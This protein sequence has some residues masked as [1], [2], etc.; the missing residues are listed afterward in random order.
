[1][2]SST[3]GPQTTYV[4]DAASSG[5]LVVDFSRN[6]KSFALS[7]W[8]QYVP[9]KKTEGRYLLMTVEQA[10]RLL[11]TDLQDFMWPDEA[12]A[13]T[14]YGNLEYFSW[15]SYICK[16]YAF[17]FRVGQLAAEQA[18]WDILAQNGRQAAQRA[19][20][21]RT[22]AM[23]SIAQTSGNYPTGHT[24]NVSAIT[25]VTG[26]WDV[27]TTARKDIK[28]SLDHAAETIMLATLGAV[29][30]EEL[31]LVISPGCARKMS[32]CQEIVDH[33]K[34]SPSAEKELTKTLGGVN[35]FGIPETL[36]GYKVVIDNAAKTT[37]RKGATK[38]QSFVMSDTSPFMCSRVGGLEGIEGSPSF[39]TFQIFLYEEMTTESK[40][41][42]DNR[43]HLGRVVENY[44]PKIVA[45]LSGYLFTLAVS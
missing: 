11:N 3:A 8:C 30:Q 9:V 26:K 35:R 23:V 39:S 19:M 32:V 5:N 17:P 16:R 22:Q 7:E 15:E 43:R 14:G 36:Y 37:S 40:Y 28:R 20:T 13:P 31:M 42:P 10:G 2:P 27:S 12:E 6:P 38:A 34:G 24:A 29:K 4:P 1:M 41:D 45:P 25:G 21:A 33:I 18:A 44:A